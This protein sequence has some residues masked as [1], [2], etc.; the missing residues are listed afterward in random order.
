MEDTNQ[1]KCIKN[2]IDPVSKERAKKIIYQMEN[3]VCKIYSNGSTGTGFFTKIPYKNKI[4]KALITNNHV[5]GENEIK[6]NKIISYIINDDKKKRIDIDGKRKRYTN[7]KLDITIVEIDED[8]DDIHDYIDIDNDI[9]NDMTLSKEK[10]INNYKNLYKNKS[11]Y[12]LNYKNGDKIL[13]SY[14]LISEINEE[15]GIH[16]KCITDTGSSGS[17]ILSLENN[18]LI[19]IHYGSSSK[20]EFNKGTLIIYA[21]IEFNKFLNNPND[22]VNEEKVND[23]EVNEEEVK[24]NKNEEEEKVNE[25]TIIYKIK[26]KIKLF[27]K[28][29]VQ[30]NKNNCKIVIDNKEHELVEYIDKKDIDENINKKKKLTIKL[31]V[32]NPIINMSH[33]FGDDWNHSFESL[34]SLPDIYK[35]DTKNVTN[36][37]YL[38]C[39][40][41]SLSSLPDIS[42]WDTGKVTDM[43]LMF[44]SCNKL[45]SL[46][47]I[48]N[49]NTQNVKNMNYMFYSCNKLLS[50]PNISKWNTQNVID[51]NS[52]FYSCQKLSSLPDISEWKT[53]NVKNMKGMFH[54]CKSLSSLPNI[55]K[56]DTGKVTNMSSMFYSCQKLSSL[57]DI[58][59]WKTLEVTDM[60]SM[61]DSCQELSSL[62]DIS[63]WDTKNVKNMDNMFAKCCKLSSLPNISEWEI[64]SATSIYHMF[65]GCNKLNIPLKFQKGK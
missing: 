63:E 54:N 27:G 36:M 56:W 29:F 58:S 59:N 37:S 62:P 7:E 41:E 23:E 16:H 30:N 45:T 60:S 5:L 34:S 18:K 9:I 24:E 39:R 40:C 12:I 44:H 8:K 21:L 20:Y 32:I 51:M 31:K 47:D 3:C 53:E 57:P 42:E 35:L 2:A 11:I 65:N 46:P 4:I 25:I 10:I 22:E 38:F 49:W 48:S 1:E 17:P 50:L 28:E 43:S 26:D 19:G 64:N 15:N 52:M 55:S 14:G 6:N 61:F 33:M 13:V